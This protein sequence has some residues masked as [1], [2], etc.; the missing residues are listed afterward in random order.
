MAIFDLPMLHRSISPSLGIRPKK[1]IAPMSNSLRLSDVKPP[2]INS[3]GTSVPGVFFIKP[4]TQWVL[5]DDY[6]MI[7]VSGKRS[8]NVA[9]SASWSAQT[10]AKSRTVFVQMEVHGRRAQEPIE[11]AKGCIIQ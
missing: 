3:P 5:A 6:P 7:G 9:M 4:N 11:M 2:C 10:Y 1:R 8:V